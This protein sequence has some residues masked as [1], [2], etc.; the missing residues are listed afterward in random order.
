MVKGKMLCVLV[1]LVNK[2]GV[3]LV[4]S[5]LVVNCFVF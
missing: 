5:F 1:L 4:V 3:G 2:V